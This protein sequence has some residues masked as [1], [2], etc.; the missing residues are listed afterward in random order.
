[1]LGTILTTIASSVAVAAGRRSGVLIVDASKIRTP[2]IK[3]GVEFYLMG[4]ENL[5]NTINKYAQNV[6]KAKR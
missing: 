6:P 3:S 4:G 2:L 1:M 5:Y